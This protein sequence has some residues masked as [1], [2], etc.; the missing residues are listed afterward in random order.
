MVRL[1]WRRQDT[2]QKE[3]GLAA[4]PSESSSFI[5]AL[6]IAAQNRVSRNTTW[7]IGRFSDNDNGS[8]FCVRNAGKKRL[9]GSR[10]PAFILSERG[11]QLLKSAA[12]LQ[13]IARVNDRLE[14]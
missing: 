9:T 6:E 3:C 5:G 8:L 1:F 4:T 14:A 12:K 7:L 11:S 10:Q 2:S 13:C